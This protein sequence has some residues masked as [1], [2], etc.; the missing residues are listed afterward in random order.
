MLWS[1]G[2]RPMK[3][4]DSSLMCLLTTYTLSVLR[5]T[6]AVRPGVMRGLVRRLPCSTLPDQQ[7][8]TPRDI[9]RS[10]RA[11][12]LLPDSIFVSGNASR[13]QSGTNC[14]LQP[15][16]MFCF[17]CSCCVLCC[18]THGLHCAATQ[19]LTAPAGGLTC[20][21]CC[22]RIAT[23]VCMLRRNVHFLARQRMLY[24]FHRQGAGLYLAKLAHT[25][26]NHVCVLE[27]GAGKS[28]SGHHASSVLQGVN[29]LNYVLCGSC[30]NVPTM[31]VWFHF[32]S[33]FVRAMPGAPSLNLYLCESAMHQLTDAIACLYLSHVNV[34]GNVLRAT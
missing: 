7:R 29:V 15:Y 12:A 26:V 19:L 11:C 22:E 1:I 24:A 3:P 14:S 4:S 13:R 31:E 23:Q 18:L 16:S 28:A 30:H 5:S 20:N 8:P 6:C 27:K 21:A 17:Y 34:S 2:Q 25:Q 10:V 32:K 33:M 9:F